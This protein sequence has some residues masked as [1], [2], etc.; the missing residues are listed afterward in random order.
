MKDPG[1]S[2]NVPEATAGELLYENAA[3]ALGLPS[4]SANANCDRFARR[5]IK[6]NH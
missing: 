2:L 3:S 4:A 5:E 6:L 1:A